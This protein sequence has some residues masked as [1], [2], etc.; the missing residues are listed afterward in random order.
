MVLE[1]HQ[2][3]LRY[4]KLRRRDRRREAQLVA[5][6]AEGGQLLPIVVL[7]SGVAGRYVVL[8]GYKRVRALRRL[9]VDTVR[10]VV[11]EL[12]EA[13]ALLLERLMRT[14]A[15]H[16]ALEQGWLL[17]ELRDRF[18]L[19]LDELARRFDRGKS[20]VSRRLALVTELPAEIQEQVRLGAIAPHAAM[21]YLVPLARANAGAATRLAAVIAPLRLTTRQVG[22]LYTG[23][24]AG[25]ERTRE[26]I[27]AT[28]QVYLRARDEQVQA[29]AQKSPAQLLLDDFGALGGLARR[30]RRRL[31]QGLWTRLL[32]EEQADVA[33]LAAR[34]RADT[35]DLFTRWDREVTDAGRSHADGDPEAA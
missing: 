7:A 18:G 9:R 32:A 34:A 30:A 13:E 19:S 28:P 21:K 6:L 26:L 20:W 12:E 31:E 11:W 2:L 25:S 10:A 24:Q 8:D 17:V 3:E 5:S 29:T 1:L 4:E 15:A 22:A 33:R 23:W 27:L 14:A 35:E 16:S